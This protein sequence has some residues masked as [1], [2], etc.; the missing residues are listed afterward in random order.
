MF[1]WMHICCKTAY[2][3]SETFVCASSEPSYVSLSSVKKLKVNSI[4]HEWIAR[5]T[6]ASISA[7]S[8]CLK[9]FQAGRRREPSM[10]FSW[11]I[12]VNFER[13]LSDLFHQHGASFVPVCANKSKLLGAF[14][15]KFNWFG[16]W[17]VCFQLQNKFYSV[18]RPL[19]I[20]TGS[21]WKHW[22]YR[23]KESCWIQSQSFCSRETM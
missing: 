5:C 9:A 18:Q 14:W 8:V 21:F 16:T 2:L 23:L 19:L 1:S 13:T 7:L 12:Y 10:L 22:L 11:H 15:Q 3:F 6:K 4:V 20:W 17:K